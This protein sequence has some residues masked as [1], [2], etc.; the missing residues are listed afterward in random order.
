[1][2]RS[3]WPWQFN[4][5]HIRRPQTTPCSPISKHRLAAVSITETAQALRIPCSSAILRDVPSSRIPVVYHTSCILPGQLH[6]LLPWGMLSMTALVRPSWPCPLVQCNYSSW[7][8][9]VFG[10]CGRCL[11][12][13]VYVSLVVGVWS[14]CLRV[15]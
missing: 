13:R 9:R 6:R 2:S 12:V 14:S 11:L 1:M 7:V 3:L 10:R 15:C 5:T 8:V 4:Y